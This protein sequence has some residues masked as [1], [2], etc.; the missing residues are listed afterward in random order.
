MY[1][2]T[3]ISF[4]DICSFWGDFWNA[5]MNDGMLME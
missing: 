5:G 4:H 3:Y 1:V 2:A